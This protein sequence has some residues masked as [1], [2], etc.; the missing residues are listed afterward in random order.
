MK[1]KGYVLPTLYVAVLLLIFGAVSI[2]SGLIKSPANYLYAVGILKGE[3]T[4]PVVNTNGALSEEIIKPYVSDIVSIEKH[5]YDIKSDELTQQKSLIYFE[6]TYMKNTGV[7]YT[8][9]EKFDVVSVLDG[10]VTKVK[11]DEVLG[12]VV[13]IE[14]HTNLRTIYY[15]LEDIDV[16]EG[17][18][19]SQ[20]EVIGTSGAN[21]ISD[22]KYNLLVE[23]YY[24]G[25]LINPEEFY[26]MDP[27]SLT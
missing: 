1:L 14:H 15:S 25:T 16:Q 4:L 5:F 8:A 7:L 3:N 17:D 22:E 21:K 10:T 11:T 9:P 23:V 18:F 12:N 13:E 27:A 24:N 6:N 2:V 19:L 26:N 20:G